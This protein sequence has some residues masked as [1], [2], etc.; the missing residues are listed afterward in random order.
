MNNTIGEIMI[1]V[2][3]PWVIGLW[4]MDPAARIMG[5]GLWIMDDWLR[6]M[7]YGLW[8]IAVAEPQSAGL[9]I[10]DYGVRDAGQKAKIF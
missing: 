4:I 10:M 3:P 7:G 5:Y 2:P 9:W 6:I 8:I 1:S